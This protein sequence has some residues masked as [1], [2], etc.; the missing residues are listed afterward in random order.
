MH[1]TSKRVV[2]TGLGA[3]TPVGNTAADFWQSLTNGVSGIGPI[4]RFDASDFTTRIAGEVKGF[5]PT[6]F[7][8]KK[9]AKR[10][11]RSTHFA[12]A[13]S[14]L[15]LEDAKLDL[16]VEDKSRIGTLIGTGIGGIDTLHEQYKVLFD[17]GPGRVSPFFVPMMIGNMA[18]GNVAIATGANGPCLDVVSACA[19]SNSSRSFG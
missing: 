16:A 7:I 3:I 13:A 8:D 11:D 5:E 14:K 4:T 9:E 2:I 12:I 18:A 19:S 6:Q 17:K 10:M 1:T 15:A